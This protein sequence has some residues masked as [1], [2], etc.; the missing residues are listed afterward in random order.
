MHCPRCGQQQ[1]SEAIKFCSRCGF[2]LGLVSE[3][4]AHGGFLPQLADL[5]DKGNKWLTRNFG[6]KI[7]LLWFLLLDFILVPLAAITDAP[8]EVIAFLAVVGFCGAK[9]PRRN[10]LP[11]F[12]ASCSKRRRAPN[13]F[14]VAPSPFFRCFPTKNFRASSE[15]RL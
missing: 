12:S 3:I 5:D 2:S 10:D 9:F 14:K 7:S 15:F 8:G 11:R 13:I 4:L 1:V 6:L